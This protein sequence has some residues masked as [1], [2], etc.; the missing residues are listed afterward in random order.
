MARKE[1]KFHFI[2]K[3]TNLLTSRYY[4]GMH[5]TDNLDD[6]YMGSGKRLKRSLSKYGKENHKVEILQFFDNRK[7]LIEGERIMITDSILK[8]VLC[9]NI[10]EGGNGTSIGLERSE[11][12]KNKMSEKRSKPY[13]EQVGEDMAIIWANNISKSL[14]SYHKENNLS[15]DTIKKMSNS[16]KGKTAWNKD[17]KTGL[18][19]WNKGVKDS[20]KGYGCGAKKESIPWNK[21]KKNERMWIYNKKLKET[22]Q[23]NSDELEN[24]V[25]LGWE[26]GRKIKW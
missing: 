5:S 10:R 4:I 16:H 20:M 19:P 12:V 13:K 22:K 18:V 1:K 23:I 3:T 11:E 2:Y 26:K 7:N 15:E 14:I 6:G 25:Y 9:I 24:W 8:D 21:G 17:K